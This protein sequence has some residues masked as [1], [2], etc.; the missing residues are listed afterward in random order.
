[1]SH[2]GLNVGPGQGL[3][4]ELESEQPSWGLQG[5][6]PGASVWIGNPRYVRWMPDPHRTP[7]RLLHCPP[8]RTPRG[9]GHS[10]SE[11]GWDEAGSQ[12]L[13]CDT[14]GWRPVL[15]ASVWL[16]MCI[17]IS[18]GR[19]LRTSSPTHKLSVGFWLLGL[20]SPAPLEPA[21]WPLPPQAVQTCLSAV[22]VP[23]GLA[24]AR[25][26]RRGDRRAGVP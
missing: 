1:M 5:P 7:D 22:S 24:D 15:S 16:P 19:Q 20:R 12:H 17:R 18:L 14:D 6:V 25:G 4:T 21:A 23:E 2:Q 11:W 3:G 9:E 8:T 26:A 10:K 13:Q